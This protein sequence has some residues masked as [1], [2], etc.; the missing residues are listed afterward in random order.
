[1][2]RDW[3]IHQKICIFARYIYV[4]DETTTNLIEPTADAWYHDTDKLVSTVL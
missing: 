2:L 4:R 3:A 1:M